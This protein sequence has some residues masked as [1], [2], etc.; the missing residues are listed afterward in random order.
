M[1]AQRPLLPREHQR[2]A[3][4]SR[5]PVTRA[6]TLRDIAIRASELS[7]IEETQKQ[8]E[9]RRLE[10][11]REEEERRR[12]VRS[13]DRLSLLFDR[14]AN[15]A[16]DARPA[17]QKMVPSYA[18]LLER[19]QAAEAGPAPSR[20]RPPI[21]GGGGR[22]AGRGPRQLP[23]GRAPKLSASSSAP[24]LPRGALAPP[25]LHPAA[26]TSRLP[27]PSWRLPADAP[28]EATAVAGRPVATAPSQPHGPP[29]EAS[30]ARP[31]SAAARRAASPETPPASAAGPSVAWGPGVAPPSPPPVAGEAALAPYL[32][33]APLPDGAF[34]IYRS[35]LAGGS[36]PATRREAEAAGSEGERSGEE[37][38]GDLLALSPRSAMPTR[39]SAAPAHAPPAPTARS[40]LATSRSLAALH[41]PL[42]LA[43]PGAPPHRR[44]CPAPRHPRR[45]AGGGRCG[46][47]GAA[48]PV[49]GAPGGGAAGGVAGAAGERGVAAAGG[50]AVRAVRWRGGA[51]GRHGAGPAVD[52]FLV[53]SHD[54]SFR[55]RWGAPPPAPAALA[56]PG[57]GSRS[58]SALGSRSPSAPGSRSPSSSALNSGA[59]TPAAASGH[60]AGPP[61]PRPSPSSAAPSSAA[62]HPGPAFRPLLDGAAAPAVF[63]V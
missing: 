2:S 41:A 54:G 46:C 3:G 26:S 18:R 19:K 45:L 53:L 48:A 7:V 51:G 23:R 33:R 61:P 1:H 47:G 42:S 38:G 50:G 10:E 5:V 39:R 35:E 17:K 20:P 58:S 56:R 9:Q 32:A 8:R 24:Q 14:V 11:Q 16:P 40:L 21:R 27:P 57:F 25:T 44:P 6:A 22:R 60:P 63:W 34:G 13:A 28:A 31:A 62:P 29:R 52:G 43:R 55:V 4:V 12:A 49:Y 15:P 30:P 59:R 37:E 36:P